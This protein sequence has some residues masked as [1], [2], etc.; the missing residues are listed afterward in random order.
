MKK[1]IAGV[2]LLLLLGGCAGPTVVTEDVDIPYSVI[3][4]LRQDSIPNMVGYRYISDNYYYEFNAN[5]EF[6]QRIKHNTMNTGITT[7]TL[8]I[9]FFIGLG[10]ASSRD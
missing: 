8:L 4:E 10:A 2:I 5:K 7:I 6:T 1:V 3:V 9:A